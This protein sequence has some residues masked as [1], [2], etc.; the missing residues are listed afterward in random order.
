LRE[1]TNS[2]FRLFIHDF[3][4]GMAYFSCFRRDATRYCLFAGRVSHFPER[5]YCGSSPQAKD[6]GSPYCYVS[7]SQCST[8]APLYYLAN[9]IFIYRFKGI[10]VGQL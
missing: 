3:G 8:K 7:S 1:R 5:P 4:V 10:A 9:P 6:G 2:L